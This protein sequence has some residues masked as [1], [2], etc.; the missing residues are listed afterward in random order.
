MDTSFS[1]YVVGMWT[2]INNPSG[3]VWIAYNTDSL[4]CHLLLDTDGEV[5]D[6]DPEVPQNVIEG[7]WKAREEH[8]NLFGGE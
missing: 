4:T 3:T 8:E 1:G 7:F 5:Y 2:I 6:P